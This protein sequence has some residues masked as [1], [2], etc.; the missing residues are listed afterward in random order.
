MLQWCIDMCTVHRIACHILPQ[1]SAT[2]TIQEEQLY[3]N[4]PSMSYTVADW[5]S[6]W[7]SSKTNT[8]LHDHDTP[9]IDSKQSR[10]KPSPPHKKI[11]SHHFLT[12]MF[13]LPGHVHAWKDVWMKWSDWLRGTCGHLMNGLSFRCWSSEGPKEPMTPR[14]SGMKWVNFPAKLAVNLVDL[15]MV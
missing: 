11:V 15:T 2:G 7:Q 14:W 3:K 5:S 13:I 6:I 12:G 8:S 4:E 1:V 10:S 9:M